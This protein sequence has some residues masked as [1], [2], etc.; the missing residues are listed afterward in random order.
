MEHYRI[1][2]IDKIAQEGLD[3]FDPWYRVQD[4]ELDPQGIIVRSSG[5]NTENYPSLLAVARAG[6]GVNNITVDKAT[7]HGICVFNT[8]G[9][10]ANAVVELVF[11]MLG[12]QA[13]NIHKCLQFCHALA[14]LPG[15]T[16]VQRIEQEKSVFKGF[17]LAGKT[18]GVIGLGKIGVRVA[19]GGAL[20]QMRVI[21]FD[22]SPALENIHQL[23]PDVE[24]SRSLAGVLRNADIL[25][26]H[27]PLN[28]K[29]QGM[30]NRELLAQ[31]PQ[32][33]ILVNYAR[34]SI[35]DELAVLDALASGQLSSYVT[36]FPSSALLCHPNVLTSPHLGAS[37]EES[38]EQCACMAVRELKSYLEYGHITHSVNFPTAENIPAGNVHTRL[39]MINRDMPG[40]IGFASSTIGAYGI[41][42]VSY[43]NE[44]NGQVGYNIIDLEGPINDEAQARILAHEGVIRLRLIRFTDK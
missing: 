37:T 38:E 35:V 24:L 17:E 33:A 40:M 2:I 19:N 6:A 26:V 23:S 32:G 21:G 1:K 16:L 31:L 42:I 5:V 22:P 29:T 41:N 10:N 30:V 3:L 39:I 13:R 20:R 36:D 15:E 27:A 44:S 34:A 14:G 28:S 9:A 8:P 4:D 12:M 7:A 11:V 18:L 43:L 25:T